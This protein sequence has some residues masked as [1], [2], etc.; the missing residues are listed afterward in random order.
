MINHWFTSD[1]HFFFHKNIIKYANRPF[2]DVKSMNEAII[3]NWNNVVKNGDN[4]YSLGDFAF[5]KI[6]YV[7]DILSRLNGNIHLIN[8]NHDDVIIDNKRELLDSGMVASISD[9]KEIRVNGQFICLFHYGARVWNRSHRGSWMLY[10]HSHGSL[11]P[12]G[13]SVDV[14]V[15]ATFILNGR[16][17]Y[18]PY[19]FLEIKQF[20][21]SRNIEIADQHE[22]RDSK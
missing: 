3:R 2:E 1:V 15:D 4:I 20:M 22:I 9:Y 19:S 7:K 14:G 8:G 10:G 11:P 5:G 18:R 12:Y 21:D 6:G 17:E 13:K 16:T